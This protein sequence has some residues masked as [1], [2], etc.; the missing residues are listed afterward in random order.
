[1]IIGIFLVLISYGYQAPHDEIPEGLQ[2]KL[3]ILVI[4]PLCGLLI[5]VLLEKTVFK[6]K[7]PDDPQ[8]ENTDDSIPPLPLANE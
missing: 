8:N 2:P 1:M 3:L 4:G 5:G 6:I 7:Q